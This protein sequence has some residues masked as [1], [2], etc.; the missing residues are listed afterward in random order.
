MKK[1]ISLFLCFVFTFILFSCSSEEELVPEYSS[2]ISGEIDLNGKNF[3][4][5]MVASYFFE[6][7]DSTL[8]YINNTEFADLAAKRLNDVEQKYNCTIEVQY[9]SDVGKTA[10]YTV[11]TGDVLY[12]FIQYESYSLVNYALSGIF[13]DLASLEN[14]DAL[15]EEKWGSRYLLSPMMWEGSLYGVLPA[16]H[17][18]RVQNSPS[19]IIAIN[20]QMVKT[21]GYEDPR[22]H[23]EGGT[24]T[25][26]TFTDC[27]LNFAH[28]NMSGEKVYSF[29]TS[30]DGWF[31]RS[32]TLS[33]G[34]DIVTIKDDG[35]YDMGFYSPNVLVAFNQVYEW[36]TGPTGSNIMYC[37]S[38][39]TEDNLNN[40]NGVMALIDAYQILSG[41]TSVAYNL[42]DFGIVPFPAGPDV[43][44][45]TFRT[46]FESADFIIAIPI[47][48]DDPEQSALILDAVYEPFEGY[49]TR[50]SIID[51]LSRNYFHDERDSEFFVS[52]TDTE[53]IFY[54]DFIHGIQ[55][56]AMGM[57]SNSKTPAEY[58][59]SIR[60]KHQS[61]IEQYV[62]PQYKTMIELYD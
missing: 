19:G 8:G 42:E 21:L 20:E 24:W 7:S 1:I 9:D 54:F 25:Y 13:Y 32:S 57:H 44:A 31:Y 3:I 47:S 35:T 15:D 49:E 27:L 56:Q 48:V 17:P 43:D 59:D 40:G 58:L 2:E 29:I 22:D 38:L 14:M 30:N 16:Q 50:D 61:L 60:D 34:G 5:G 10:Y 45:K 18:L 46:S 4:Y 41:T 51:Y 12:D 39:D 53:H 28:T 36:M 52:I 33:N 11:S 23:F 37:G 55:G 26:D 62:L 6:G